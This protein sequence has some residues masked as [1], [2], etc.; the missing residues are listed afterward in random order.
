MFNATVAVTSKHEHILRPGKKSV[1]KGDAN[2]ND[3]NGVSDVEQHQPD[4]VK[5]CCRSHRKILLL[6]CLTAAFILI[7][8]CIIYFLLGGFGVS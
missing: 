4:N 1:K 2:E 7:A 5:S 3:E 6:C 8:L